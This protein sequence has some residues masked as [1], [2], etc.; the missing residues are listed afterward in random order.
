MADRHRTMLWHAAWMA[1]TL[2]GVV[3]ALLR[4]PLP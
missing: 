3:L 2:L 1:A 4:N